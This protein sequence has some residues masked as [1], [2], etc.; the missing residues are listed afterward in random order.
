LFGK[1]SDDEIILNDFG[2]IAWKHWE[3][4]PERFP[5]MTLDVFQIMPNHIHGIIHVGATL[6]V[7]QNARNDAVAHNDAIGAGA[8]RAGAKPCP[9]EDGIENGW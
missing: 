5:K 8:I 2:I 7:A 3:K 6:A 9:Y 1:I 4:L